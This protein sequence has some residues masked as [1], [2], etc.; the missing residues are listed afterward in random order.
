MGADELSEDVEAVSGEVQDAQ[1]WDLLTGLVR[2]RGRVGAAR[3]LGVNFRTL[4]GSV[5][6]RKLSPRML[7][8]L[9]EMVKA[10]GATPDESDQRVEALRRRVDAVEKEAGVLR[11]TLEAHVKHMEELERRVAKLEEAR[12]EAREPESIVVD[13]ESAVWTPPNRDYGLPDPGVVTLEA[14]PDEEHAFG[15]VVERVTEWR[16]LRTSGSEKLSQVDRARAEERR[17]ELEVEM[18]GEFGLTLP[19]ETEPLSES[20][21]DD[22]LGWRWETLKQAQGRRVRAER[23]RLLRRVLTLG[24]WWK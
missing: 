14:Q 15:P 9:G 10:G 13:R 6:S 18:I 21:R 2:D 8:A 16:R 12:A 7:R 3:A 1:L 22:H 17:W 19:P 23:L 20:R 5:D 24:L 4:A 11:E